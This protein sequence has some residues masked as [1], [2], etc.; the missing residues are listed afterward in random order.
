MHCNALHLLDVSTGL[1]M[2]VN[3]SSSFALARLAKCASTLKAFPAQWHKFVLHAGAL[4]HGAASKL[5]A[6]T[7][8]FIGAN[9]M[10]NL[11]SQ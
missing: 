5:K 6:V 1:E 10:L 9:D 2:Y 11:W 4:S 7:G 3:V 8:C